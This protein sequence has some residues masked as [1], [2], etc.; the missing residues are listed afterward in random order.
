[1]KRFLTALLIAGASTL[2]IQAHTAGKAQR[3]VREA[4]LSEPFKSSVLGV[5]AVNI[6][7]DTLVSLG[8]GTRMNPASTLKLV[9]TGLALCSLGPDYRFETSLAYDGE[10]CDS[11][12]TGN[13][14]IVGGGD[15]TLA[16]GDSISLPAP[17]LFAKWKKLLDEAGIYKIEGKVVG[18]GRYF[19]GEFEHPNWQYQ[20]LGTY[21]GTGCNGL[22]FYRNK[23]DIEVAA[24]DTEG[25][26]VLVG[27]IY[28]NTPWIHYSGTWKTGPAGSGDK[29]YLY[30][31][32]LSTQARMRGT[33][34]IDRQTKTEEC[35]NK[36]PA[37][38]CAWYFSEYLKSEGVPVSGDAADLGPDGRI[39]P[40]T[41]I[42]EA[43]CLMS[44][45]EFIKIGST[46]S[47]TLKDIAKITLW[48]SDN[49]YSEAM[50]RAGG[51]IIAGSAAYAE[52]SKVAIEQ[53]KAL[54]VDTEGIR[55]DD[56]SGLSR[57]NFVTP[58][59]MCS[60]LRAMWMS[61]VKE[62]FISC[63]GRPGEGHYKARLKK[64]NNN[65]KSRIL[66]K[67]GSMGGVQCFSG[68]VLPSD[69]NPEKTITFAVML[70]NCTARHKDYM[71]AIDRIVAAIAAEN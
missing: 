53:L 54:E 71:A 43:S 63:I 18:D 14:Y 58:S 40:M 1:M 62:A 19:D 49:L 46:F 27:D 25:A 39:R 70:G 66:Y 36:F 47:P 69:G 11:T 33:F 28:P 16:S 32:T 13:L 5:L 57:E 64:E 52:C 24:G 23:Q 12:L 50:F 21:Y 44:G 17:R 30:N 34:A 51:K 10:I 59:F 2:S 56:G 15:P 48:R 35:S 9:T 42:P 31:S 41:L 45:P 6:A 22:C 3:V 4:S 26:P 29:L 68:Y 61:P 60:F 65:L 37:L 55:I 67:S 38:T 7:G 8:S 20:D